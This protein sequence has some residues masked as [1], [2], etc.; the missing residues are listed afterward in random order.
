MLLRERLIAPTQILAMT[1]VFRPRPVC[2]PRQVRLRHP[3]RIRRP[4]LHRVHRPPLHQMR[5]D[6]TK[7][8][9]R[10]R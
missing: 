3:R 6:C 1:A 10:K 2:H 4:P 9:N 7:T 8:V 5:C